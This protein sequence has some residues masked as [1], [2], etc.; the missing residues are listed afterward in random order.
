MRNSPF[1]TTEDL[2]RLS[3]VAE[4]RGQKCL[5][6]WVTPD[7]WKKNHDHHPPGGSADNFI[8]TYQNEGGVIHDSA[9]GTVDFHFISIERIKD[10]SCLETISYSL[11]KGFVSGPVFFWPSWEEVKE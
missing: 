10:V 3:K 2:L 1:P 9:M 6:V 7:T 5:C 8:Q 4:E 11:K